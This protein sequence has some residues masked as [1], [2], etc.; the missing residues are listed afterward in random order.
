MIVFTEYSKVYYIYSSFIY[1][2]LF[3]RNNAN[4]DTSGFK[5][6]ASLYVPRL[7]LKSIS[8]SML[9][10]YV[11][12]YCEKF[13]S[14]QII[15][16]YFYRFQIQIS[17]SSIVEETIERISKRKFKNY[18]ITCELRFP[19]LRREIACAGARASSSFRF[20]IFFVGW[21]S[22]TVTATES[23]SSKTTPPIFQKYFR[24]IRESGIS[25]RFFTSLPMFPGRRTIAANSE[26]RSP[27][28][29]IH[30]RSTINELN[31]ST[32][33]IRI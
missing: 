4:I 21:R 13:F 6:I 26:N 9:N 22:G 10:I 12:P 19:E 3:L 23:I 14:L 11:F 24:Q 28:V 29:L 1:L 15:F 30:L 8:I 27:I 18:I 5:K 31:S 16:H 33:G 20:F 25:S 7:L 32:V 17:I 2:Y